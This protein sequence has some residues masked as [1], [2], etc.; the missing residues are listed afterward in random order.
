M[1]DLKKK[2]SPYGLLAI[3]GIIIALIVMAIMIFNQD[4]TVKQYDEVQVLEALADQDASDD[5][6]SYLKFDYI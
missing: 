1:P 6:E 3:W 2:K 4:A 5:K